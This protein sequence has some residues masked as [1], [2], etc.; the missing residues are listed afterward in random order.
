MSLL[1]TK[2]NCCRKIFGYDANF[3]CSIC[4]DAIMP[5]LCIQCHNKQNHRFIPLAVRYGIRQYTTQVIFAILISYN[6]Y[7][8]WKVVNL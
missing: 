8:I 1:S 7:G 2:C 5:N 6:L 4:H 3:K